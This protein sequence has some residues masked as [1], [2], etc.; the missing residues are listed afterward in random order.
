MFAFVQVVAQRVG[1]ESVNITHQSNSI[2][3]KRDE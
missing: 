3:I 1:K 2:E